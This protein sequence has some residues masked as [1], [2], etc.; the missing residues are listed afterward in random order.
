MR[1]EFRKVFYEVTYERW[2]D[3]IS[4]MRPTFLLSFL[5]CL[6]HCPCL[7]PHHF[8]SFL[9]D[10][11]HHCLD[12]FSFTIF[13]LFILTCTVH[14][15]LPTS[16]FFFCTIF[17]FS[18]KLRHYNHLCLLKFLCPFLWFHIFKVFFILFQT[19]YPHKELSFIFPPTFLLYLIIVLFLSHYIFHLLYDVISLPSL[20]SFL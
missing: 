8:P 19:N 6:P 18:L 1:Q 3:N 14:F 17:V 15:I 16:T 4:N 10:F 7:R 12:N 9:P 13:L 20:N 11:F 5:P 2:F